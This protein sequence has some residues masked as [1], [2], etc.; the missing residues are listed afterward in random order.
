MRTLS[1]IIKLDT[2]QQSR[3]RGRRRGRTG[4]DSGG[5][6]SSFR[7]VPRVNVLLQFWS[8]RAGAI[9]TEITP[10]F[11]G[12]GDSRA[13]GSPGRCRG[14]LIRMRHCST[15]SPRSSA[16]G[17]ARS[18]GR[19]IREK[20]RLVHS[21]DAHS[22]TPGGLGLFYIS[23]TA[24]AGK[25]EAAVDAIKANIA[26]HAYTGL[27]RR[28]VEQ[29]SSPIRRRRNQL[30]QN[31]ERPSFPPGCGR[32][33]RRRRWTTRARISSGLRTVKPAALTRVL[34][35][36]LVRSKLTSISLN[37]RGERGQRKAKLTLPGKTKPHRI[38]GGQTAQGR[39]DRFSARQS[40]AQCSPASHLAVGAA[41]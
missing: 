5:D 34:K 28:A 12:R 2:S 8:R 17:T 21:I 40:S 38:R 19:T 27:H 13:P 7:R 4:R 6:R 23:F 37:P 1:R 33:R 35:E 29:S 20:A 15:C 36:Y 10:S 32:S 39:T 9:I 30:P 24:D 25:R 3:C 26:R 11:R 14:S 31:D 41:V 18:S 22:W 16:V